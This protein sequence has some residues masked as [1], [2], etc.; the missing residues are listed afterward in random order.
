[1]TGHLTIGM[2]ANGQPLRLPYPLTF[3]QMAAGETGSGKSSLLQAML[4]A[5]ARFAAV[6]VCAIDPKFV[7]FGPW[8][9]R[10]SVLALEMDDIDRLIADLL[11]LI[12]HRKRILAANGLRNWSTDYGPYVVVFVD[13]MAEL[14]GM[15]AMRLLAA[16]EADDDRARSNAVRDAKTAMQFR[17]A[18]LAS[19]ARRARFVGVVLICATQ[20]PS[21]EVIDQQ[22]RTQLG[23]TSMLRVSRSEQIRVILG[24][25]ETPAVTVDSIPKSERGGLWMVGLPDEPQPIRARAAF[26][27]D[28]HI[29]DRVEATRHLRIPREV[30]FPFTATDTAEGA[31]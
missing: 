11:R 25:S 31:A 14:G 7:E 23:V 16:L 4:Y 27:T 24:G 10:L 5:L 3:H 1:M 6:A 20:Y 30:L 26:V 17:I 29:A 22:V 8:R 21:V 28:T 15:D 19:I 18:M 2:R 13:E 12:D 9:D